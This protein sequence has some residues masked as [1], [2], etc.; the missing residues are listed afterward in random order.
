[1]FYSANYLL[2]ENYGH[3]ADTFTFDSFCYEAFI[4]S[5]LPS[6]H[7]GQQPSHRHQ[8]C[9]IASHFTVM[10]MLNMFKS[11]S[12]QEL[13]SHVEVLLAALSCVCAAVEAGVYNLGYSCCHHLACCLIRDNDRL[14]AIPT[15]LVTCGRSLRSKPFIIKSIK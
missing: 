1:M 10:L 3:Y 11:V 7:A 8:Y 15:F 2:R 13:I 14:L 5:T 12:M 6:G 9:H 4:S